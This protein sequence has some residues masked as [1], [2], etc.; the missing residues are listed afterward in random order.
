MKR[1][2][3]N[4]R[5]TKGG[6]LF[7]YQILEQRQLLSANSPSQDDQFELSRDYLAAQTDTNYLVEG[8]SDV[9]LVSVQHGLASTTTRLQQTIDGLPV[10]NAHITI[11]QNVDGEFQSVHHSLAVHESEVTFPEIGDVNFDMND[12]EFAA[13]AAAGTTHKLV[14]ARG[15]LAWFVENDVATHVWDITVFSG[16][17]PVGDFLTIVDVNNG[18]VLMQEN[19]A[20]FATGEGHVFEPNPWQTQGSGA[21]LADNDDATSPALDAQRVQVTLENLDEG[22]GLLIGTWVDLATLNSETLAD[23][24]ANEPTRIY[25]YDRDDDRFEQVVVYH[26]VDR[27]NSYFHE[28]GFDD[29]TGVAN[30]IRDFPTLANAH[31]Y[32]QDQSFYSTGND[33]IHMGDGGVDDGEDADIIAHEFGHAVQHNQNA[34]W[35]GGQ[36]GAMG[37]GFG[38][39]LAASFFRE[40]GDPDFQALHAP[41]V[42]EWDALSYSSDDP[43]NLRRVDGTKMFPNDLVGQVH[44]DGEIWS[45]ALWDLNTN[46]GQRYADQIILEQHFMLPANADM[47][48]AANTIL[49]ANLNLN[50][51]ENLAQVRHPFVERGIL[52]PITLMNFDMENYEAG[53]TITIYVSDL[54]ATVGSQVTVTSSDG[55]IEFVTLVD[56]G[57]GLLMGQLA[58]ASGAVGIGNGVLNVSGQ[59]ATITGTYNGE[60]D[61]AV[62]EGD[63]VLGTDDNDVIDVVV[64][65]TN[66]TVTVNDL[67]LSFLV[68]E[69]FTIDALAGYDVVTIRDSSTGDAVTIGNSSV[70]L[71]GP[72]DFSAFNVESVD[73]TSGGGNDLAE[74]TGTSGVDILDSK[75]GTTTL[76]GGGL[77]YSVHGYER[78]FVWG[79]E[80]NDRASIEDTTGDDTFYATPDFA[81]LQNGN[82]IVNVRD[83]E[84]VAAFARNGGFDI[85][86]INGTTG[87]DYLYAVP[88]Y[89]NFTTSE[90][91]KYNAAFFDR[92]VTIGGG[93]HDRTNIY[94]TDGNDIYNSGPY[95]A[96]MRGDGFFNQVRNF[97][98]VTADAGNNGDD[99]AYLRDSPG[100]DTFHS[101]PTFAVLYSDQFR[102]KAIGFNNVTAFGTA[103]YDNANFMDSSGADR[104]VGRHNKSFLIG[105]GFLNSAF[106][107]NRTNAFSSSGNDVAVLFGSDEDDRFFG[108]K[109]RSYIS[110][111]NF[112]N[113]ASSFGQ[114]TVELG[115]GGFDTGVFEDSGIDD[116]FVGNN[117]RAVLLGDDYIIFTDKLDRVR[118]ISNKGGTDRLS[119]AQVKYELTTIGDWT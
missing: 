83:F 57:N 74:I 28:L 43:P 78:T 37:E 86:T 117:S 59:E 79:G 119:S 54:T 69:S 22:T 9:R 113:L 89:I 112:F 39:Y 2:R 68:G 72:F 50:A 55:D 95:Q 61:T 25:D 11:V 17:D 46:M 26:V 4:Q 76:R 52:Q 3:P 44:A 64:G 90:D 80:G 71:S 93:G 114:V 101:T 49:A 27:I 1:Q 40:S 87:D 102:S 7:T 15:E 66:V 116:Q 73:V 13:M 34:A 10:H 110:G 70:V 104:Y 36:M 35:G 99:R 23:N 82:M 29:D 63:V 88:N 107:F 31:W 81:N 45:R 24:D 12:A 94:G 18:E 48:T 65:H 100:A 38:D 51:G 118:A 21:G 30:G 75:N 6:S 32:D 60:T 97:A 19:R 16:L 33:A 77:K 85:A 62:I 20:A 67:P 42:G 58:T 96:F 56:T 14:P 53:D 103:G 108:S 84:K 98:D 109:A 115:T 47:P 5:P 91:E 92:T 8:A 111:A 41:A 106:G 105:D